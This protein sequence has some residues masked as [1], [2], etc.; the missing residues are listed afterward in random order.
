MSPKPPYPTCE[1]CA[2]KSA[3]MRMVSKIIKRLFLG[4]TIVLGLG[5]GSMSARAHGGYCYGPGFWPLIPLAFG[6]GAALSCAANSQS[7]TYPTY[8]YNLPVVSNPPAE[9]SY[10]APAPQNPLW[11][12]ST[13]GAGH[14]VPE[15]TPYR[16][17]PAERTNMVS[18]ARAIG[19]T[20]QTITITHSA[21]NVP[22]YVVSR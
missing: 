8:G 5:M 4:A 22:V 14:W 2:A 3:A 16:Y 20:T 7:Y 15:P 12:P 13:P 9:T 6:I 11:I 19:A 1:C 18:K 10:A 21:G 17:I